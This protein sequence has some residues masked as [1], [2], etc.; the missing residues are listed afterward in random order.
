MTG[1][2]PSAGRQSAVD[3]PA[4]YLYD[5]PPI[6]ALRT[7]LVALDPAAPPRAVVAVP[8]AMPPI[9]TPPLPPPIGILAGSFDPLTNA[10]AALARAA[11]DR[12]GCGAVYLALSRH[13]VDKESRARP[14]QADRAL[15]LREYVRGH[16]RH[17]L[18]FF[19]RGLYADQA[20]AARAA[21]PRAGEIRFIVGFD[22]ARQIFDPRYY[23]DRDAA[24]RQLFAHVTLLVAPRAG[25]SASDLAALLDQPANRPYRA[26]VRAL[27]FDPAYAADSST[28]VRAAAQ[29]GAPVAE[30]VPPPAAIFIAETRPYDP[31]IDNTPDRDAYALREALLTAL[32]ADRAWAES[33]AN[34]RHL[35]ALAQ[36]P[37]PA[38]EQLLAWLFDAPSRRAPASLRA[39]LSDLAGH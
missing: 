20:V 2:P 28:A 13:T 3:D 10:H 35:H 31:S 29:A 11:L 5:L 7:A 14:T 18:L 23:T 17:G 26:D 19:N 21:F 39:L 25:D 16:A 38:G 1:E 24:L 12:G 27:P 32:G 22:K 4:A 30:L 8:A 37:T 36:T 34:F 9:T 6:F 15:V 33:R